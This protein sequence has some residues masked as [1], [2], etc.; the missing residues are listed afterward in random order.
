MPA[1]PPPPRHFSLAPALPAPRIQRFAVRRI[2]PLR[3]TRSASRH[4]SLYA[5]PAFRSPPLS[6]AARSVAAYPKDS[7]PGESPRLAVPVPPPAILLSMPAQPSAPRPFRWRREASPRIQKI[8]RQANL[9]AWP[10]P[11]RLPPSFSLCPP[12]LPLPAPFVGGAKR[13]RVSKRFAARRISPLW[14]GR[15]VKEGA[16]PLLDT[17]APPPTPRLSRSPNAPSGEGVGRGSP[18]PTSH[19]ARRLCRWARGD[20]RIATGTPSPA[21]FAP[22]APAVLLNLGT[23]EIASFEAPDVCEA[24]PSARP[25]PTGPGPS[26]RGRRQP[27]ARGR[28]AGPSRKRTASV[29][30]TAR[31]RAY[32]VSSSSP[33]VKQNRVPDTAEM[34]TRNLRPPNRK[35][36]L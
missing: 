10:Y 34:S 5:R 24:K 22:T 15:I 30:G 1:Q 3:R 9:P 12:S 36:R 35:R 17:P 32:S 8:R 26:A 27:S 20:F 28:K 16:G 19:R 23:A 33:P 13:R 29:S 2:S 21:L 4:P 18:L 6:L 14:L 31:Q 7:P 25:R 11:F